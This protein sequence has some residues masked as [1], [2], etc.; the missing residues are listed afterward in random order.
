MPFSDSDASDCSFSSTDVTVHRDPPPYLPSSD[1]LY[2]FG[3]GFGKRY[4]HLQ[5]WRSTTD[6]PNAFFDYCSD[7]IIDI[8]RAVRGLQWKG[9]L[10]GIGDEWKKEYKVCLDLALNYRTWRDDLVRRAVE[11]EGERE[12]EQEE[13][14]VENDE[15]ARVWKEALEARVRES[16]G[17]FEKNV[18]GRLW[19]ESQKIMLRHEYTSGLDCKTGDQCLQR[20]GFH[21]IQELAKY[22][23]E[24]QGNVAEHRPKIVNNRSSSDSVSSRGSEGFDIRGLN[25]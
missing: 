9:P 18:R 13:Q 6:K 17:D 23:E 20:R 21:E 25:W 19:I 4:V 10:E 15:E 16:E 22:A 8:W 2:R 11:K 12:R 5:R 7:G 1:G 14:W 24:E 3:D